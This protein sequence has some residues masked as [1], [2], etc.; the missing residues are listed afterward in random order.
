MA[1]DNKM[2]KKRVGLKGG[3][4]LTVICLLGVM[5]IPVAIVL[6]IGMA[7]TYAASLVDK[8]E[9]KLKAITVGFMNFAGCY[10][11]LLDLVAKH[12]NDPQAAFN[13]IKDPLNIII[14]YIAAAIGWI[15]ERGVTLGVAGYLV[16]NA[17]KRIES[18]DDE[19]NDMIKRWG[20]EVSGDIPLDAY[21]F[22]IKQ[23]ADQEKEA[24]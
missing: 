12:G 13:I 16:Q 2:K 18:I 7:P 10:P 5:F 1:K 23:D 20:Q 6:I 22:P 14:M 17:E 24:S 9:E 21:G 15:I 19:Q 4:F 8:T 11:Y 3:F